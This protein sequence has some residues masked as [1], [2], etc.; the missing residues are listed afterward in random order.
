MAWWRSELSSF[1]DYWTQTGER[2]GVLALCRDVAVRFP[3]VAGTGGAL[4]CLWA[5]LCALLWPSRK[6]LLLFA[7]FA[8]YLVLTF[9]F[10]GF[11]QS[12]YLLPAVY[13]GM[14][15]FGYHLGRGKVALVLAVLAL[16]LNTAHVLLVNRALLLEP[17]TQVY[18]WLKDHAAPGTAVEIYANDNYLPPL[19]AMGL[20]PERI[21]EFSRE[22]FRQ[23]SPEIVIVTDGFD[24]S[25]K[26]PENEYIRWL[27]AGPEGYRTWAF[28]P[29]K[30]GEATFYLAPETRQRIWPN[31]TVIVRDGR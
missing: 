17:R 19:T 1:E 13:L 21:K 11:V 30:E 9:S 15:L 23:R 6:G 14:L 16:L 24:W 18:S 7:L 29:E 8:G 12:R 25:R 22:A 28:G 2:A 10:L 26:G 5:T 4:L 31:M 20:K 27:A 3:Y